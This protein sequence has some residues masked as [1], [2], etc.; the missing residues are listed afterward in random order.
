MAIEKMT[1][2]YCNFRDLVNDYEA[3]SNTLKFALLKSCLKSNIQRSLGD[4]LNDLA[5]NDTALE[6]LK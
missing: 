3:I 6:E 5:L 4:C 1:D 2:I